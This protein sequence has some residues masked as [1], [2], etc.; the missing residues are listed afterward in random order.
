M[1]TILQQPIYQLNL[2]LCTQVKLSFY[3]HCTKRK[4]FLFYVNEK[5][6]VIFDDSHERLSRDYLEEQYNLM[7][8]K[9]MAWEQLIIFCK[10]DLNKL[11]HFAE[12]P[13]LNHPLL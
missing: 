8:Q 1:N 3:Y 2:I 4:P 10:G 12:P 11:S 5:D 13:E 6:Y 9:L 7:T